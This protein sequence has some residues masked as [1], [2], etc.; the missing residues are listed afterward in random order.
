MVYYILGLIFVVLIIS[1]SYDKNVL[2]QVV[3]GTREHRD[4]TKKEM[5]TQAVDKP[6]IDYLSQRFLKGFM[7]LSA[8]Y[9]FCTIF[10]IFLHN[11]IFYCTIYLILFSVLYY[12]VCTI[13]YI[14]S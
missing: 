6:E 2:S 13:F 9:F 11:L 8:I 10:N 12:I 4:I 14:F 7:A 1:S 5:I 3:S